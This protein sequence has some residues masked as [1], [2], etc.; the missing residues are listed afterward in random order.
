MRAVKLLI[1]IVFYGKYYKPLVVC[2]SHF[3]DPP[4]RYNSRN[5]YSGYQCIVE[6]FIAPFFGPFDGSFKKDVKTQPR[7]KA[8]A[9]TV[10]R[11]TSSERS[12]VTT[13]IRL[14]G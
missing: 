13:V 7:Y 3:I 6:S 1:A 2:S 4:I 5:S 11:L 9:G 8:V 14:R 12:A 10:E